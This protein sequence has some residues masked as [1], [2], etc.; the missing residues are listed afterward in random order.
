MCRDQTLCDYLVA[1]LAPAYHALADAYYLH[2]FDLD[3]VVPLNNIYTET[4][5]LV[6]HDDGCVV[7]SKGRIVEGYVN[8]TFGVQYRVNYEDTRTGKL[9][10]HWVDRNQTFKATRAPPRPRRPSPPRRPSSP[11]ASRSSCCTAMPCTRGRSRAP[12]AAERAT[13]GT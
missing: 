7:V 6:H 3:P 1:G 5:V 11:Q 9:K 12:A 10:E 2:H 13:S 8:P 4:L